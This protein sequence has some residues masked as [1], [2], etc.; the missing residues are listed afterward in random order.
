MEEIDL[1]IGEEYSVFDRRHGKF[2]IRV[3]DIGNDFVHGIITGGNYQ[4]IYEYNER[5]IGESVAVRKT[6]AHFKLKGE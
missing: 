4:A 6:L 1:K 2:S 5:K 3:T